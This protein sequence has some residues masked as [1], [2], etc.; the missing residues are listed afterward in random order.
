MAL[1]LAAVEHGFERPLPTVRLTKPGGASPARIL[2]YARQR[3]GGR[4]LRNFAAP[5]A[6]VPCSGQIRLNLPYD[7]HR[8]AQLAPMLGDHTRTRPADCG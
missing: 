3:L 1:E 8:D 6:H 7:I 5:P 4:P 2:A